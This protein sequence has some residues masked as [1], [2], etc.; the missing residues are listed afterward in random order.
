MYSTATTGMHHKSD[1]AL[2]QRNF[3]LRIYYASYPL[4]SYLCVSAELTYVAL[5]IMHFWPTASFAFVRLVDVFRF[6]LLPGCVLKQIV[7]V[8][9][10]ASAARELSDR[11]MRTKEV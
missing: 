1:A 9:Q 10:L 4:F 7:N 5:Y 2:R 6:A 11:D 3:V 8:A